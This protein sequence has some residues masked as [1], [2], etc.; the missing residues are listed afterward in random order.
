MDFLKEPKEAIEQGLRRYL[1]SFDLEVSAPEKQLLQA[2][3]YALLNGGKRVRPILGLLSFDLLNKGNT[4]RKTVI[5]VLL[6]LEF[7]HAYSLVHDDLPALDN[8]VLRRGKPTVWKKYGEANAL[9]AGD[10][11]NTLAFE[12]IARKAPENCLKKL[13]RI[14]ASNSG[15]NGM[16]GGQARDLFFEKQPC[17]LKQLKKTHQKKTGALIVASAQFGAVLAQTSKKNLI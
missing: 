15:V 1:E 7:L 14:L 3:K 11:L 13:V 5:E 9:L 8:D 16:I 10:L 17:A 12:N 6:S 2:A 4:P